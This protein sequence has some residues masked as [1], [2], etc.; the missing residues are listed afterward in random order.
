MVAGQSPSTHGCAHG[1]EST[2][3]RAGTLRRHRPAVHPD[4]LAP[5][6]PPQEAQHWQNRNDLECCELC[7]N[8]SCGF[9]LV[10]H[11]QSGNRSPSKSHHWLQLQAKTH[12]PAAG[13]GRR[14]AGERH[15]L[16]GPALLRLLLPTTPDHLCRCPRPAAEPSGRRK[17]RM[18]SV[19]QT[20]GAGLA[21]RL[22]SRQG[23]LAHPRCH[24]LAE[25]QH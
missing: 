5:H 25:L 22:G 9:W 2:Q 20:R 14:D 1:T 10:S 12:S 17:L 4:P 8:Y 18:T 16:P 23:G 3:T 21:R 6:G 19:R 13:T 11:L 15:P 7:L 24:F